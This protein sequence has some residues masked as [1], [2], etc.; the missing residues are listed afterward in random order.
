MKKI[1]IVVSPE[2]RTTIE[3]RGFSGSSCQ[4]ATQFLE[5]AL[6]ERVGERLTNEFYQ[7]QPIEQADHE[8]A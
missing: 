6:G 3:T 2:G 7:S 1:E 8:R 5:K 4:E